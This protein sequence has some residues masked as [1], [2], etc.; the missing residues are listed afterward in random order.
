[1]DAS[2]P[3]ILQLFQR[4][5]NYGDSALIEKRAVAVGCIVTAIDLQRSR[6]RLRISRRVSGRPR[7]GQKRAGPVA[8]VVFAS[9]DVEGGIAPPPAC[10]LEKVGGQPSAVL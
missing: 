1:M 10:A 9:A 4:D 7:E 3:L 8:G 6:D 2:G 5:G